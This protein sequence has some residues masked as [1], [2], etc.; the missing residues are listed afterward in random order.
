[1]CTR[2]TIVLHVHEHTACT[3]CTTEHRAGRLHVNSP[4][5][6]MYMSSAPL[7]RQVSPPP[8][9]YIQTTV[10]TYTCANLLTNLLITEC[11][12]H[13]ILR[14]PAVNGAVSH[15]R[16]EE[17]TQSALPLQTLRVD[18]RTHS[19]AVWLARL[20]IYAH[21]GHA[22]CC[23]RDAVRIDLVQEEREGFHTWAL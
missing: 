6:R 21:G 13:C 17:C 20:T 7:L 12:R 9:T 23:K 5:Y 22:L 3:E 2:S 4:M 10:L 18:A 8:H 16:T 15:H 11:S 1:M 19:Q 14:D